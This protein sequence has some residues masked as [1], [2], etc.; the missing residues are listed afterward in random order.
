LVVVAQIAGA[1]SAERWVA[2]LVGVALA[3]FSAADAAIVA[4]GAS[5][6]S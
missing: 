2:P 5:H 6:R 3:A 1:E 4:R